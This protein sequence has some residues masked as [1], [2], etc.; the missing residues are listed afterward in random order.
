MKGKMSKK[1]KI[2]ILIIVLCAVLLLLIGL[3]AFVSNN[4]K[5]KAEEQR[6]T[7]A[8]LSFRQESYELSKKAAS[9]SASSSEKKASSSSSSSSAE[10]VKPT[11][12]K[13]PL[14]GEVLSDPSLLNKRN[15]A[16][17][18]ENSS[19]ALPHYGINSAGVIYECPMEGGMTRY[20]A[21]FEDYASLDRIGNLRSCRPYFAYIASEYDAVYVHFG[22]S[23]HGEELL[24]TGIV[25]DLNGTDGSLND[26]WFRSSDRKSPHNAY[27]TGKGV[28]E[29]IEKKGYRTTKKEG[30][31]DH[32]IFSEEVNTLPSGEPC[33]ALSLYLYNNQPYF[34]YDKGTGLYKRYEY[35]EPETDAVDGKQIM[36]KNIIL[37]DVPCSIY[38]GTTYLNIPVKGTGKGKFITQGKIIDITWEKKS[39]TGI[40]S[41]Y[42]PDGSEIELNPGKTWVSL[43]E[44]YHSDENNFYSTIE[45]FNA[46]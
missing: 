14:T 21:V 36:V 45:E 1:K 38:E 19:P 11:G 2:I 13:S 34:I 3:F 26:I 30:L 28:D 20:M 35:D 9:S 10:P 12:P 6:L 46:R 40:T 27:T 29:G 4:E 17:M 44:K 42:M 32:F 22:Q 8:S 39:D 43:I 41:Y 5:K 33:E 31:R 25:A 16:F 7:S 18:I 15:V 37:Q 24:A 23:V